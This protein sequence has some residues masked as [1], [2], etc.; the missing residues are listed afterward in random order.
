MAM[1]N[2]YSKI[3]QKPVKRIQDMNVSQT[4][5]WVNGKLLN[6]SQLLYRIEVVKTGQFSWID[7]N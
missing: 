7:L 2:L 5:Q 1:S 6:L 4:N 3:S